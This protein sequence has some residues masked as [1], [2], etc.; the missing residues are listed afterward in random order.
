MWQ[1]Q[2]GI[3]K[4]MAVVNTDQQYGCLNITTP[5]PCGTKLRKHGTLML[6]PMQAIQEHSSSYFIAN[7]TG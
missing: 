6:L 7:I 1:L 2:T 3:P 4:L 5:A